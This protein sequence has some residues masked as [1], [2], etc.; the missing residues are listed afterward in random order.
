MRITIILF[1]AI[2]V[3]SCLHHQGTGTGTGTSSQVPSAEAQS[4]LAKELSGF[5]AGPSRDCVSLSDL[6]DNEK[7]VNGVIL[8]RGGR[9]DVIYVNRPLAAC[10]GLGSGR[11]IRIRATSSRLCRG[12]SI[13]VF[14]PAS[15]IELGACALGEF[16]EYTKSR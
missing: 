2:L 16:T 15:G 6:G 7:V 1:A 5:V 3:A 8:F 12:D 11:A 14:D 13:T 9:H 10:A 4:A